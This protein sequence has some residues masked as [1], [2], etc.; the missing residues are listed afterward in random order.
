M[1]LLLRLLL[2][3]KTGPTVFPTTVVLLVLRL[4]PSAKTCI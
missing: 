3:G 4:P 1:L 2:Q